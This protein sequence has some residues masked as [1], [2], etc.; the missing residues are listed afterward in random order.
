MAPSYQLLHC[1]Q[2]IIMELSTLTA[3]SPIDGRYAAKAAS[4]R[5]IFSEFALIRFR[6]LIEIRWLQNLA[7]L[8][9]L[10]EVPPLSPAAQKFLEQLFVSFSIEDAKKIKEI[11]R[12]INHD[13]KA[14]EYFL[15]EKFAQQP[16]L[17]TASEFIH[18]ACTSEDINNLA[19]GLMLKTAREQ[20]LLPLMNQIITRLTQFAH[21]HADQPM[22]SRT[23]GQPAT[24]T[25]LGK[26]IANVVARLKRQ[27]HSF[28]QVAILGKFNGAVGNFNAHLVAY[29]EI[30]WENVGKSF[31]EHLGLQWNPYTTQIEPH[32]F[33]A[34]LCHT[35]ARFN[36]ILIDFDRDMWSYISIGY[37]KLKS[38]GQEVGSSTMPHKVNP[39]DFENSE[40][41]LSLA[42]AMLQHLANYLPRSRWQRDLRDSTLLRNIGVA[43]AHTVIA[44]EVILAGLNKLAADGKVI[45]ADL[46]QHWEILA[47]A[48]QT[49]LRRYHIDAPYEKLKALTRGKT[50]DQQLLHE[51]IESIEISVE[52]KQQLLALTPMTYVGNAMDKA[53]QI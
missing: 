46:N 47:E 17:A 37:F 43:C 4:L 51:F 5:P 24:P 42:N 3:L 8:P 28:E 11:E 29:P 2:K 26:E 45:A 9:E 52:V 20:C 34:E 30:D 27:Y 16:E 38:I 44:Y 23:H 25:T 7:T 13:V 18:F 15:K 10:K 21:Q 22:L 39:I 53:K 49:V 1:L 19:Y 36:N 40:G 12:Q 33:I 14:V 35:L 48:I 6:L 31:V 41:N 50:V 32:D